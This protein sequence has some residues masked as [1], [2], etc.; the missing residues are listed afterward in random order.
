MKNYELGRQGE[1]CAIDFLLQLGYTILKRNYRIPGAEIDMI[2]KD[3]DGTLAFVE[4]KLR[5]A[6]A[7]VEGVEAI[8]IQ[9]KRRIGM[10]AEHYL[11]HHEWAGA[12][13]FDAIIITG[14]LAGHYEITHIV[15]AF[16][17]D[18]Y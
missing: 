14:D 18:R 13:R 3:P 11:L 15:Q 17:I 16:E 10:A 1:T 6:C 7:L 12:C 5:K 9:K 8:D 4:V 2:A